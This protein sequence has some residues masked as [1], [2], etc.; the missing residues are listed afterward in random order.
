MSTSS[1]SI[2]ILHPENYRQP[3]KP[4]SSPHPAAEKLPPMHSR[5]KRSLVLLHPTRKLFFPAPAESESPTRYMPRRQSESLFQTYFGASTPMGASHSNRDKISVVDMLEEE[6][7]PEMV[8]AA[9]YAD[10]A[11]ALLGDPKRSAEDVIKLFSE[12]FGDLGEILPSGYKTMLGKMRRLADSIPAAP[13]DDS[14]GR[15]TMINT[16]RCGT[17]A[18]DEKTTVP[19]AHLVRSRLSGTVVL[20]TSLR[21]AAGDKKPRPKYRRIKTQQEVSGTTAGPKMETKKVGSSRNGMKITKSPTSVEKRKMIPAL[22]L[23][24]LDSSADF[25]SE[26]YA[27]MDQFS[28]SWRE[29]A[30]S[31]PAYKK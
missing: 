7:T 20:K 3:R 31:T 11:D 8:L 27:K 6:N 21:P 4:N 18:E 10:K 30:E 19:S 25:N 26:F 15:S 24:G 12:L 5:V 23:E 14:S 13:S 16:N 17:A 29:Q 28:E 9:S 2:A 22:H 1:P